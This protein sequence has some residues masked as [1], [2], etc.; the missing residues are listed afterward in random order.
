MCW[1]VDGLNR[2]PLRAV[3][4]AHG[5]MDKDTDR[6]VSLTPPSC[7]ALPPPPVLYNRRHG[8]TRGE[9]TH[10]LQLLELVQGLLVPWF[11]LQ[12]LLEIYNREM[13]FS[14]PSER[15]CGGRLRVNPTS[16][17]LL[18]LPQSRPCRSPAGE[19]LGVGGV[20]GDGSAAVLLR[21]LVPAGCSSVNARPSPE[22][23][24]RPPRGG[25]GAHL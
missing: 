6:V 24:P 9:R 4:G 5:L 21:L 17:G 15:S 25:S 23:D 3:A 1:F 18:Q 20:Q 16:S 19:S 10:Q 7:P 13:V 14:V 12:H 8:R 11:Q 2:P 22:T